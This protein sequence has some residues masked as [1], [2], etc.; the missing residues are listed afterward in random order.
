MRIGGVGADGHLVDHLLRRV[1]DHG[2]YL[3]CLCVRGPG[4]IA[5]NELR[6]RLI[7]MYTL[8]GGIVGLFIGPAVLG[9]ISDL[10]FG[11][12]RL[13]LSLATAFALN[14]AIGAT[15]LLVGRKR[16]IAA[17]HEAKANGV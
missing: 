4:A 5:P 14:T 6:G 9:L 8:V 10:V 11:A 13:D 2:E 17:V 12:A 1:G 15:I 3:R 16:Y 7:A